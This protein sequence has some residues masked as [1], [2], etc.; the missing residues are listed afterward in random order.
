[1]HRLRVGILVLLLAF[2]ARRATA[3]EADEV[4]AARDVLAQERIAALEERE[5][6]VEGCIS[7]AIRHAGLDPGKARSIARR[8]RWA[9]LLPHLSVNVGRTF[10]RDEGLLLQVDASN[11]L[12]VHTG[13]SLYLGVRA[14][15][16]L[17]RLVFHTSELRA[18][19]EV[20]RVARERSA[21]A[22]R[23]AHVYYQRRRAQLEL[24]LKPPTTRAD[25]VLRQLDIA[26]LSATLDELTG[27]WF[28][29]E[30][31]R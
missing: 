9:G 31:G 22:G 30:L 8:A 18:D 25:V 6:D 13:D 17:D 4:A 10:A 29:D 5:P 28:G 20:A 23:V 27:G 16:D 19:R 26:E 3:D 14:S 12:R 11:N 24:L 2:V 7:A 21:L 15:W 1:M